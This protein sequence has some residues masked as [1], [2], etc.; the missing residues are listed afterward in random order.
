MKVAVVIP[1]YK[2]EEHIRKVVSEIPASVDMII[3]VNDKSPD[4][5]ASVL[6]EIEKNDSRVVV[7]NHEENKGVGGAMI[8]GFKE[9]VA[10][11]QRS[12]RSY[13]KKPSRLLLVSLL[14]YQ[15]KLFCLSKWQVLLT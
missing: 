9:A 14:R 3:T 15:N 6:S 5:T 1:C 11:I 8:T 12:Y 10:R 4:G 7:V 2:V 13:P